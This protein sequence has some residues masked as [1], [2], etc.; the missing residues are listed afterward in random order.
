MLLWLD[1]ANSTLA[2]GSVSLWPD[3]SGNAMHAAQPLLGHQPTAG[4]TN[5]K[6]F[7]QFDGVD[8]YLNLPSGFGDFTNGLSLFAVVRFDTDN[9]CPAILQL[10]NGSE[11]DDI[12][13]QRETGQ[14]MAYE[15]LAASFMSG[16]GALPI[17][18]SRLVTMTHS[19]AAVATFRING[20][21]TKN[22]GFALPESKTRGQ[23][24]IGHT[25]YS[26]CDEF[27]GV[28]HEILFYKRELVPSEVAV[29]EGYL[30][31][32]WGCCQ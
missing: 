6:R 25:L 11:I 30:Q 20:V 32:K 29:V 22:Q 31:S 3:Q 18:A 7:V 14:G 24:F 13:F 23:N 15:V 28:I 17:G 12:S 9:F 10:S 1:A 8:D 16:T 4:T 27:G 21:Q 26:P 19:A 5:G 2:T